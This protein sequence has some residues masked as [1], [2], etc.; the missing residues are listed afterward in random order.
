MQIEVRLYVPGGRLLE[1]N[2]EAGALVL[3]TRTMQEGGAFSTMSREEVELFCIDHM[4]SVDIQTKDDALVFDFQSITSPSG[5]LP[6]GSVS[7]FEAVMQV[8]HVIL[9]DFKFEEDAFQRAKQGC[10]ENYDMTV[11]GLDS[12][13]ELKIVESST[14]GDKRMMVP[15]HASIESLDLATITRAVT[16]QLGP[17]TVEISIS[18]DVPMAEIEKMA[19]N[20]LGTVPVRAEKRPLTTPAV[21][22]SPLGNKQPPLMVYFADSEERAM[23]YLAVR[24]PP[25][26]MGS[27]II[28]L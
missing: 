14:G 9:T 7:G 12:A 24:L 17:D 21:K 26:K 22:F 23:G 1:A 27:K 25:Q 3:G 13:C 16:D 4:V 20:Y 8:L 19:I 28:F 11:K 15:D 6:E 10:L 18:G 2:G 5:S